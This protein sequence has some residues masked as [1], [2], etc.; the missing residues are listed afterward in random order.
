MARGKDPN[1]KIPLQLQGISASQ[2]LHLGTLIK[3]L[4]KLRHFLSS[5]TAKLLTI[6]LGLKVLRQPVPVGL[7]V[8]L[9]VCPAGPAR[10][11]APLT[12][13]NAYVGN[14]PLFS[15]LVWPLLAAPTH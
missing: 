1:L 14:P 12:A 9:S 15:Q 8:C 11:H 10:C 3:L 2:C 13:V 7:S 6:S 4:F 5:G